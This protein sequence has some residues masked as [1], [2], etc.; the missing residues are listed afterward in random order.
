MNW[1]LLWK[2]CLI[3]CEYQIRHKKKEKGF[4]SV[5]AKKW[6]AEVNSDSKKGVTTK[7][8]Y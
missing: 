6:G 5:E 1:K 8:E 7:R 2:T 3:K 4:D